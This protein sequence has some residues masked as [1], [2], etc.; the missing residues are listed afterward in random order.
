MAI[1]Q[2]TVTAKHAQFL[3]IIQVALRVVVLLVVLI[4]H[5]L[6]VHIVS[7]LR[8]VAEHGMVQLLLLPEDVCK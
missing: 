2:L 4:S 7:P 6:P 1:S 3:P 5:L 8:V